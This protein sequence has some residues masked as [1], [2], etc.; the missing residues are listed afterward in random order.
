MK[1]GLG[2]RLN[3]ASSEGIDLP[4]DL[5]SG[6]KAAY[7]LRYVSSI[8]S[9]D[10][11][12]VRRSSDDA[13]LGFTPTEISD[14]TLTTWVGGGNNGF[15]KTWYDQ[16]GTGNNAT[17]STNA[18]QP[19]I[20]SSGLLINV[21]GKPSIRFN[22]TNNY[23]SISGTISG[24]ASDYTFFTVSEN[25]T[26]TGTDYIFDQFTPRLIWSMFDPNGLFFDGTWRGS[27]YNPGN[28]QELRSLTIKSGGA[29]RVNGVDIQTGF[30]YTPVSFGNFIFGARYSVNLGWLQSD[31]QEFIIYPSDQTA[32][33]TAI[34][35]GINS[36][37]SIY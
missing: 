29:F 23:F 8:Y 2:F 31:F 34:E 16:S 7:S 36:Y 21:N 3:K 28:N 6:A 5:A 13:E 19:T 15:V 30:S 14:G 17:Q 32:N 4:L 24:T 12:L 22:G 25:K 33:V 1:L 37:Y 18:N 27:R 26:T 10:V 20:V 9:G 35:T 11:V